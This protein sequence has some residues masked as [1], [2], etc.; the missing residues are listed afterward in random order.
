M[1]Y[2]ITDPNNPEFLQYL[3]NRDFEADPESPAAGDLGPEGII[4]IPAEDSP[5]AQPLVIVGNE[6]SGTTTAYRVKFSKKNKKK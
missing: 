4:F 6:V 5:T 3:N 1:V 2:N